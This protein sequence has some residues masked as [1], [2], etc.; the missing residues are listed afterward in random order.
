MS[1]Y[2]DDDDSI[3]QKFEDMSLLDLFP[4]VFGGL[5]KSPTA[6]KGEAALDKDELPHNQDFAFFLYAN[7]MEK[8]FKCSELERRSI[9]RSNEEFHECVKDSI[10]IAQDL[11]MQMNVLVIKFTR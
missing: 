11:K 6:Q 3:K 10:A 5:S 8:F 1:Y 7:M 9:A 4:L 2:Y